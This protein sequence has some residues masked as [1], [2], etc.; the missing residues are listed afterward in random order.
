[1]MCL[2]IFLWEWVCKKKVEWGNINCESKMWPSMTLQT[3][4]YWN[5][6]ALFTIAWKMEH[7]VWTVGCPERY[8][9]GSEMVAI[10]CLTVVRDSGDREGKLLCAFVVCLFLF[11]LV[12]AE[13]CTK[14]Q[15]F[16]PFMACQLGLMWDAL[17]NEG[18]W[19]HT[20]NMQ[21]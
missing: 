18:I 8:C 11:N 7:F 19:G 17:K 10:P 20:L 6:W 16:F 21:N 2:F 3:L 9:R 12:F 5:T 1:M 4:E 14:K 15:H 13:L